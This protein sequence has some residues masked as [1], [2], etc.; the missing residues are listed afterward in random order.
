MLLTFIGYIGYIIL[1]YFAVTWAIGLRTKYDACY[2]TIFGSLLFTVAATFLPLLKINFLH[3]LWIVPSIFLT[4][5]T[6]PYI[7]IHNI[8]F[9]KHFIKKAASIYASIIRISSAPGFPWT[10]I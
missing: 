6:I 2:W 10:H 1:I 8:P 4:V 9:I 3:T 7:F 5:L